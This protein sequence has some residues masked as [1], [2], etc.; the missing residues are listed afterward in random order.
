MKETR[1]VPYAGVGEIGGNK[2]LVVDKGAKILLDFGK[3]FSRWNRFYDFPFTVPGKE[4][5][6]FLELLSLGLIPE[7]KG[8]LIGLYTERVPDR[9]TDL[10]K[11]PPTDIA[12]CLLSHV[13]GDHMGYLSLLNRR[14][15]SYASEASWRIT[16]TYYEHSSFKTVEGDIGG[17]ERGVNVEAFRG[18]VTELKGLDLPAKAVAIDH[19]VPGAYAFLIEAE[20]GLIA[21]T[22]DIRWHGPYAEGTDRFVRRARGADYLLCDS[23][24]VDLGDVTDE[25]DVE[26]LLLR[27]LNTYRG[28]IVNISSIDTDRINTIY[29]AAVRAGRK[30]VLNM[31]VATALARLDGLRIKNFPRLSD[32]F[33]YQREKPPYYA[34]EIGFLGRPPKKL[35][36]YEEYTRK[37]RQR[38]EPYR[39]RLKIIQTER[40]Y[41]EK[42]AGSI[43]ATE[44][45]ERPLDHVLVT[46]FGSTAELRDIFRL[47]GAGCLLGGVYIQSSSEPFNEEMEVKHEK[48][49]SWVT[50]LGMPYCHIHS[51]GHAYQPSLRRMV[52]EMEPEHVVP[53]H[54]EHPE[55]F[56]KLIEARDVIIP[57]MGR[58]LLQ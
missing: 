50:E 29:R 39:E 19:S 3:P 22:G 32:M 28:V 56:E 2:I 57:T 6:D 37:L 13:H 44:M 23:T 41:G 54:C 26:E 24:N 40:K 31:R 52:E 15:R 42:Y 18:S 4:R 10:S 47:C 55:V 11:E 16:R 30:V 33:V 48:L 58:D 51:S 5:E 36:S 9:A 49:R 35:A 25:E 43:I 27:A 38:G 53:I 46:S 7:P 1:I 14:I 17:F 20:A 12:A 34:W 8:D 21:Y 45:L